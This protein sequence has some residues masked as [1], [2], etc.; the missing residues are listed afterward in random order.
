MST[1]YKQ[2]NFA[3]RMK[4]LE[5]FNKSECPYCGFKN[6]EP[7]YKYCPECGYRLPQNL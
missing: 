6:I 3:V 4:M 1:E 2:F 7:H 5:K